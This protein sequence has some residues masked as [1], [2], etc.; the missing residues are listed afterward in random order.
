M[1]K[2][3]LTEEELN[4]L[5]RESLGEID[6]GILQ[7]ILA[8]AKG[9]QSGLQALG[10]NIG[11]VFKAITTGQTGDM[12]DP[13][14]VKAGT[15]AIVRVDSYKKKVAKVFEEF[16]K[17]LKII[18]GD[19]FANA[20]EQVR[21]ALNELDEVMTDVFGSIDKISN[22]VESSIKG[23]APADD[24]P[25]SNLPKNK[26]DGGDGSQASPELKKLAKQQ[27]AENKKT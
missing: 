22:S 21:T 23:L 14:L 13:R 9:N 26:F 6:E 7:R 25:M 19:N 5:I 20:P 8:R 27:F 1:G 16:S 18:F 15:T 4:T 3:K 17:D 11:S 2:Q 10:K 24:N 12:R